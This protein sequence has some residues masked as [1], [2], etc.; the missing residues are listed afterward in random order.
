MLCV[1]PDAADS[2][3]ALDRLT[4]LAARLLE[5]PVSLVTII[6][7]RRQQLAGMTGVEEPWASARETPLS[8]SFCKYLVSSGEPLRIEDAR[9]HPL[10]RDSPAILDFG[11]VAYLGIPLESP[12]GHVLGGLCAIDHKPRAWTDADLE[13]LTDLCAAAATEVHLRELLDRERQWALELNDDVV[14]H[15]AA[16]KLRLQVAGADREAVDELAIGLE[17]AQATAAAMLERA[18]GVRPGGLRRGTRE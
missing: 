5:V 10:V 16:A 18:G 17:I 2:H 9:T 7:D 13:A 12:D 6:D 15:L 8:Y 14:Q 4:R 11:V 1:M 3:V